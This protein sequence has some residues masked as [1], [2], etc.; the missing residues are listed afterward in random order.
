L[1]NG[2]STEAFG[3]Y[4]T[5]FTP[6]STGTYIFLSGSLLF[7]G[8]FIAY[9]GTGTATAIVQ[10]NSVNVVTANATISSDTSWSVTQAYA[11]TL[12]C[13]AGVSQSIAWTV[14]LPRPGIGDVGGS[15][16]L[17]LTFT[18]LGPGTVITGD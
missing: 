18:V 14:I 6:L 1:P 4:T 5:E 2:T 11:G 8:S 9:A 10:F 7:N 3:A 13:V 17:D 12:N 16:G 15:G